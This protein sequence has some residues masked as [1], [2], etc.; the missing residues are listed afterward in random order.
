MVNISIKHN[1]PHK[2]I[3]S[4]IVNLPI[5]SILARKEV[6]LSKVNLHIRAHKGMR[7]PI[8]SNRARKSMYLSLLIKCNQVCKD[9]IMGLNIVSVP[10]KRN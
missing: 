5:K 2:D 7:L 8:K 9:R 1:Q 3:Q 10:I 6:R 4:S